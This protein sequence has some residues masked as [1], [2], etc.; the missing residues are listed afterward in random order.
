MDAAINMVDTAISAGDEIV[1]HQTNVVEDEMSG[2][3]RKV[4]PAAAGVSH[5]SNSVENI[6]I[7]I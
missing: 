5:S 1:K 3:A 2:E 6:I 7:E 4:V